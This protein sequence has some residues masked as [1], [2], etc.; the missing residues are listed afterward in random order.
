M[1]S[2]SPGQTL[3]SGQQLVNGNFTLTMQANGLLVILNTSTNTLEF[4]SPNTA[5]NPPQ[6]NIVCTMVGNDD[7]RLTVGVGGVGVA[8]STN[9]PGASPG[10]GFF[11]EA[12][13]V[14]RI[15]AGNAP[16]GAVLWTTVQGMRTL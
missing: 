9:P 12:D 8:T 15:R 1:P 16:G 6:G 10:A 7:L 4:C 2:L 5:Q 13:G 11:L 3:G 14:G